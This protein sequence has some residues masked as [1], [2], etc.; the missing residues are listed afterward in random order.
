MYD[1]FMMVQSN[2][3]PSGIPECTQYVRYFGSHLETIRRCVN[4]ARTEYI[5]VISDVCLYRSFDFNYRPAPWEAKQIH[6]WAS[7]D[8]EQ[9]DT[10]LINVEEFKK[11]SDIERLEYYQDVQYNH[12]GVER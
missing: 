11:Q 7:G 3:H 2:N 4:K 1:T 5:W 12:P 8:Q 6:C 9:G 10:F